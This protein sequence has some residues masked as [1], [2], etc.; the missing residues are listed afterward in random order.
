MSKEQYER[1]SRVL[2]T[3]LESES[4]RAGRATAFVQR[5]SKVSAERFVQMMVLGTLERADASLTDLVAMGEELG[6]QVSASGLNQRIDDEAVTL[7]KEVLQTALR[8]AQGEAVDGG[9][10]HAFAAVYIED[11]SY[12]AL[13]A[14]MAPQFRGSGGNASPAAARLYLSYEYRAGTV[15][16]LHLYE[17]CTADQ[18]TPLPPTQAQPTLRLFDLGFFKQTRLAQLSQ[19]GESF[20][21]RYHWQSA[22]YTREGQRLDL[23]AFLASAPD[24]LDLPVLLGAQIRLPVR[25]LCQRVPPSVMAQRHQR[26]RTEAKRMRRAVSQQKMRLAAW[27]LFCTNVPTT[28]WSLRQVL[29]VYRLRWQVELLFKLWK[30]DAGLDRLGNW[31]SARVLVQLYA[32]LIALVLL[33]FLL[34]PLRFSQNRELSFPKALPMLQRKLSCFAAAIAAGWHSL[35]ALLDDLYLRCQRLALKDNRPSR[36]STYRFLT[37]LIP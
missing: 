15:Q 33:H 12:L 18:L 35:P 14:A 16:T 17:G 21:C 30:S 7:L 1:I 13:P 29:A 22:L 23:E 28:L 26:I 36:P 9:L 27:N 5:R 37:A 2:Q 8:H 25:L 31:R 3:V 19:Q 10:L 24:E 4:E 6:V 20:I 32:R 34:A 11:S